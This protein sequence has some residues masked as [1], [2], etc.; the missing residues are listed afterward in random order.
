MAL[1]ADDKFVVIKSTGGDKQEAIALSELN[2]FVSAEEA[3]EIATLQAQ[4]GD[5]DPEV[6]ES[7]ITE[8]LALL[9]TE[10]ETT[11]TGLLDRM[12]AAE[13][14]IGTYAG[15]SDIST[16]LAAALEDIGTYSGGADIS[17]DL[18]AAE[19]DIDDLE[20]IAPTSGTPTIATYDEGVL[21]IGTK[22]AEG[23]T[24]TIDTTVYKFRASALGAGVAASGAWT[25][26]TNTLTIT[27]KTLGFDGNDLSVNLIDPGTE[28]AST[29]AALNVD[30]V[31]I[32]VTLSSS[33]VPAITAT[34]ADVKAAIEAVPACHA[35]VGCVITGTDT[36]VI[37]DTDI[38]LTGGI[39]PEAAY[40]V[41]DGGDVA[42]SIINL[43]KAINLEGTAG[44]HYGT[45]T[46]IHPT[47]GVPALVEGGWSAT[48]MK[49]RAKTIGNITGIA[50]D[51]TLADGA[52]GDTETSGGV[53][54]TAAALG[55]VLLNEQSLY[56]AT[57]TCTT[58]DSKGWKRI[59]LHYQETITLDLSGGVDYTIPTS[60]PPSLVIVTET[61]GTDGDIF[62]PPATGSM[63]QVTISIQHATNDIVV[64]PSVA[65]GTDTIN[66]AAN[67]TVTAL[68]TVTLL[69]YASGK[70][71]VI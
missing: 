42:N 71:M 62:L 34:L 1:R 20:A 40:D 26:S 66:L 29:T 8:D 22:P 53:N 61:D 31:T 67:L 9:Q 19:G 23:A 55:K 56:V 68:S 6:T 43:K 25:D 18:S 69:D 11:T 16:E 45:G 70:W 10:V 57:G 5:Y 17:T 39:D 50:L 7:T 30:G 54:G 32:D 2:T 15:E 37:D 13:T 46:A 49:V 58:T 38:T 21:T 65:P 33:A 63:N 28:T 64:N 52:W 3:P 41:Y 59:P 24:V 14:D 44:T 12:T 27:A 51:E 47:V 48:T 60:L 4:V 36:T 35:L